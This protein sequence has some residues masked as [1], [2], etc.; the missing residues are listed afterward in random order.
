VDIISG[1]ICSTTGIISFAGSC[2]EKAN[3]QTSKV[4][5]SWSPSNRSGAARE[6]GQSANPQALLLARTG[7]EM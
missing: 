3:R 6:L 2:L 7:V 1:V 4:W 5:S